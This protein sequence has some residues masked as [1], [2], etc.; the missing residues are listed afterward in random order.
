ME[1]Q[2]FKILAKGSSQEGKWCGSTE[3]F[4]LVLTLQTAAKQDKTVKKK[5]KIQTSCFQFF[6]PLGN[7]FKTGRFTELTFVHANT[8][9]F[10]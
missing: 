7:I 4:I 5:N 9:R 2:S 1:N 10:S 3:M 8:D 6:K